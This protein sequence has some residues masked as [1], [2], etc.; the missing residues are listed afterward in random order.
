MG[1]PFAILI[2]M[3]TLKNS[4]RYVVLGGLFIIPFIPF[5]VSTSM[6]FPFITGKGFLF[7]IL[8]EIVFGLYVVLAV[9]EPAFRPRMSKI[10]QAVLAFAGIVLLADIFGENPSKSLWSNYERMEG[11]VLILHLVLYYITASGMLN[12]KVLWN[13]Y[14]NTN[15][16]ASFAMALYSVFQLAG[17]F[18]INQGGVRVDG[19]FGNATYLAIYMVFNIFLCLYMLLDESLSSVKK[20]A[21]RIIILLELVIL[22]FTATRGAI[23]GIIGGLFVT[24]LLVV[25][26]EKENT[27]LKKI[28]KYILAG[29]VVLIIGFWA[30]KDTAFVKNS[31]VLGRFSN[32]SFAEFKTQGRSF[33][34]P[35]ALKGVMDRPV[36]GWGQ[37]NFNFVF[38]KYYDPGMFG[39]EEWFDRTHNVVL[40]W[41]IA[42]GILGFVAYAL[43]YVALLY[44]VWRKESVL[45]VS[46]KSVITGMISA[47]VFHNMFVFDNLVSYIMFFTILAMVDQLSR[48]YISVNPPKQ[49]SKDTVN[50]IVFPS[51]I[52]LTIVAV[53]FVNVPAINANRTLIKAMTPQGQKG[54]DENLRLFKEAFAENS[55]GTS[56][57][58][59]QAV[60]ATIQVVSQNGPSEAQKMAFYEMSKEALDKKLA[61]TPNDARYLVFAG[62]F[63]NRIG[64]Y[65]ESIKYLERAIAESP[66]KQTIHFELG[67]SYLGKG[68]P[69]KTLEIFK[70]AYDFK[71]DSKEAQILL[72]IASIYAKNEAVLKEATSKLDPNIIISD[73]RF[74]NAYAGIGDFNSAINILNTRLT[75]DPK[76]KDNK[77]LLASVYTRSGQKQRAIAL[78]QEMINADPTF[79]QEGEAYI[80][81]IN[82]Q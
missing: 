65:D 19:T 54:I 69:G 71:S 39:Q 58:L 73:N 25:W 68:E 76:N 63:Y 55:F 9:M 3:T 6:F 35:M 22:Y 31:P 20:W 64:Q 74:V 13:R 12:S 36:L 47:Y 41:L 1:V 62:T 77:L 14:L 59:E 30:M 61:E 79:K 44:Y 49:F 78:I 81:Q 80:Q 10:T 29:I 57:V 52:I 21:Y 23:L 16:G 26:K 70:K 60:T 43:I 40:D 27:S 66:K 24:G 50:Y 8:M 51:A 17:V 4:L 33:V 2:S 48:N 34:W 42:G 28:S 5:I 82:A 15:I 53:Y 37:E 11:F 18:K 32:L 45:S 38:N 7:R 56:E 46:Q 75:L 72:A 67:S